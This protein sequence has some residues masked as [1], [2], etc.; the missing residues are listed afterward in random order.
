MWWA[1]FKESLYKAYRVVDKEVSY[2]VYTDIAKTRDLVNN[3]IKDPKLEMVTTTLQLRM[4][5]VLFT[6]TFDQAILNY[7]T[8]VQQTNDG[9]KAVPVRERRQVKQPVSK[10]TGCAD[11][12]GIMILLDDFTCP[13]FLPGWF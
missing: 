12:L 13:I 10:L 2:A 4:N 6:L 8:R 11:V 1:K 3:R 7:R 9:K 5:E